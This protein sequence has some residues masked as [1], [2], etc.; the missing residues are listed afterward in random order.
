MEIENYKKKMFDVDDKVAK[1]ALFF[2]ELR[3]LFQNI[4]EDLLFSGT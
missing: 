4:Q 1:Y 2:V 3:L